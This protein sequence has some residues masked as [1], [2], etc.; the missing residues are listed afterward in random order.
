MQ[1]TNTELAQV[2]TFVTPKNVC[3]SKDKN[4]V[5]IFLDDGKVIRKHKNFFKV[6]LSG[7]KRKKAA[8]KVAAAN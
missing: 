7:K 4:W 6:V 5:L 1:T 3:L 2:L 8:A